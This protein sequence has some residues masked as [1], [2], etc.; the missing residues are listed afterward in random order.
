V[1]DVT[2]GCDRD[3]G[4]PQGCRA[5]IAQNGK[6][7]EV[8]EDGALFNPPDR[9]KKKSPST[10]PCPSHTPEKGRWGKKKTNPAGKRSFSVSSEHRHDQTR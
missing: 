6:A 3:W 7:N 8:E 2:W 1:K 4:K 5:S 9:D 10:R